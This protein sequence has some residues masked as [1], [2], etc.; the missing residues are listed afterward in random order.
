MLSNIIHSFIPVWQLLL[1]SKSLL[2][3]IA[4]FQKQASVTHPLSPLLPWD[5][6][7]AA[8]YRYFSVNCVD[9]CCYRIRKYLAFHGLKN[10]RSWLH[11]HGFPWRTYSGHGWFFKLSTQ[12]QLGH[13]NPRNVTIHSP[14]P[15]WADS[16]TL[17]GELCLRTSLK[18]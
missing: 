11:L 5:E 14:K 3:Y 4:R 18:T 1:M 10:I 15:V 9:C 8:W 16:N 7:R 13:T 12:C 17:L 2:L 6:P